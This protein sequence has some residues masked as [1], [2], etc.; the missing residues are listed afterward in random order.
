VKVNVLECP[1]HRVDVDNGAFLGGL[2]NVDVFL[3][4]L[5]AIVAV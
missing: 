5:S 4:L 3:P 2:N 1:D